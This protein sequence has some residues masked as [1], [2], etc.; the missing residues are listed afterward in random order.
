MLNPD[1]SVVRG[2]G[3]T[4]SYT[5]TTFTAAAQD[6]LL[7]PGDVLETRVQGDD[8]PRR[9]GF[10]DLGPYD[11][12]WYIGKRSIM[13]L[14]PFSGVESGC[15]F[16]VTLLP[17]FPRGGVIRL[18][19]WLPDM[20]QVDFLK[21]QMLLLA[22]TVQVD[23]YEPHLYLAPGSRLLANVP[24]AK[25]W[26]AKRDAYT[27]PG[28]LPE[29]NLALRFGDY[30]QL[31]QLLWEEDENVTKGYGDGSLAIADEVLPAE[32]EMAKLPFAASEISPVAT[33]MLRILNYEGQDLAANPP[34]YSTVQAKPRLTLRTVA[35]PVACRLITQP[36]TDN[37]PAVLTSTTT[38]LS[39]FDSP[40]LSLLLDKT[41]LGTYW[42]DLRSMLEQ[43]RYLTENYRLTPRDIAE[44]DFSIPIWDNTLGDYFAV[45]SVSEFDPRRPTEVTLCRLYATYLPPPASPGGGSEFYGG[46]FD[47]KGEFY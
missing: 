15:S 44:L 32:Y 17:E 26:S 14:P 18:Q 2:S 8:F 43:A 34:T 5:E 20:K 19:D 42:L 28:R 24:K 33:T 10:V 11:Q 3:R 35:P 12:Q 47:T 41:V 31:N 45:S 1:G 46:E 37:L 4:G 40:A 25:D 16:T 22:L 38:V 13:G 29:R 39:Y 9:E 30:G 23:D 27:Q 36:A 21:S 6:V 7:K